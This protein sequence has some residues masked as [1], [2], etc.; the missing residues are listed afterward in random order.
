MSGAGPGPAVPPDD[1]VPRQRVFEQR[2]PRGLRTVLRLRLPEGMLGEVQRRRLQ[3]VT[4]CKINV[5]WINKS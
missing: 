3:V 1:G 5:L 4:V 2:Q